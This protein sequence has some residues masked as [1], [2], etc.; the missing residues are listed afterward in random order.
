M[1]GRTVAVTNI[2]AQ[3]KNAVAT[4]NPVINRWLSFHLVPT[5]DDINLLRRM[6]N[7]VIWDPYDNGILPPYHRFISLVVEE[8]PA[9]DG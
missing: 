4:P 1:V 2:A 3:S 6:V 9:L 5:K 8:T 7:D